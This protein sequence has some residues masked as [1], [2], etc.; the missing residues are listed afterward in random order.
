MKPLSLFIL[1]ATS[2]LGF[3]AEPVSLF[4]GKDLDNWSF[5]TGKGTPKWEVAAAKV[6]ESNP[7]L[8][9]R[10]GG[11]S[12]SGIGGLAGD[13]ISSQ[14]SLVNFATKH[15]DSVD[16]YSKE[17]FGSCLIELEVMVPKG[18]NSGIYVMG[19]YEV[20]V[21]DSSGK[22]DDKMGPGDM[23]AIYGAAVPKVNACKAP[24]EWQKYV[25]DWQAPKFDAS[26]KKIANAK[27]IKVELN[28]KVMHEN[29]EMPGPTPSGVTGKEAAEGPIMFQG[30]HGPVA[31]RNI[32]I[33][34]R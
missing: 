2:T 17:K 3:A 19:E 32:K 14:S 27:F 24:G 22:A 8:L 28:G 30:D 31:Y 23:G 10:A 9:T 7:K 4:N 13:I 12:G 15:G 33:T 6:D 11:G 26:G 25:I 16:I 1:L 20:Q 21:F 34:P 5:K 29:L 18:S